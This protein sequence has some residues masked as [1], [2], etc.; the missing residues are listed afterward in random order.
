[1]SIKRISDKYHTLYDEDRKMGNFTSDDEMLSE[2]EF[3][4]EYFDETSYME[5]YYESKYGK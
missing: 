1:M 2:D 3:V 4:D 5:A